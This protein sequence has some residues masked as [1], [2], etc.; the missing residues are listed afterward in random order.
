[1]E[2]MANKQKEAIKTE[3]E[4]ATSGL[5]TSREL[6]SKFEAMGL[7]D[8]AIK[9]LTE[10]VEKQGMEMRK[11]IVGEEGEKKGLD[12]IIQEKS[13]EIIKLSSGGQ[14]VKFNVNK[15][16]V[17]RASVGSSTM[18]MRLAEVGQ[19]P[20]LGTV[21]SGLFRHA[22]VSA[23]SNGVIR[24]YDQNAIT[25]NAASVAEAAQKPES[26]ITWIERTLTLEKI[27]DSIPVSKEAWMDVSFIK[28]EID[29]LL[30]INLALKVDD[31]LYDG[32]GVTPN[33]KGVY[34]S[35]AA[36]DASASPYADAVNDANIYDLIAATS[37]NISNNKQSKYAP[38]VV[39]LNPV[40]VWKYK[41]L[42]ATDG[43][44]ILPPFVTADGQ[45][46]AGMRVIETSQVAANTMVV[47]DFRFGTIYDLE[48]INIEMGYVNDQFIK[49][50]MTILAEQRLGLLIR[51]VDADAFNKVISISAAIANL[52]TP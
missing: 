18:A 15:T 35:A 25:R 21:M 33:I 14:N 5:M 22:P 24:Y 44:Y 30:N 43:H 42:K 45:T 38:N 3:V 47:G 29:R 8:D 10:A 16:A 11:L 37:V 4:A 13:A 28:S 1:M 6:E 50:S 20:Y 46:I 39:L 27:A 7:K 31:L 49:N 40:D 17:A 36:F 48:G 12:Q 2:G 19:L 9:K 51:T 52:E 34:T 32:D 41:V 26:A 23:S